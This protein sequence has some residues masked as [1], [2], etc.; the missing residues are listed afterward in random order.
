VNPASGA[1]YWG[2]NLPAN[3]LGTGTV[4]GNGLLAFAGME[5]E[6]HPTNGIFVFDG[7]NGTLLE[8]LRDPGNATRD[9]PDCSYHEFGQPVWADGR[10]WMSNMTA[11][12]PWAP[13]TST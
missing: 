4:N 11:L 1:T 12:T 7:G 3:P 10:L 6:N 5:W 9:C 2:T 13:A 8:Q